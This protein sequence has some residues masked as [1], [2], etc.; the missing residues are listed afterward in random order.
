MYHTKNYAFDVLCKY[1]KPTGLEKREKQQNQQSRGSRSRHDKNV[2]VTDA[3]ASTS[4][5]DSV[6][7]RS[8][9]HSNAVKALEIIIELIADFFAKAL[10]ISIVP[11]V[12]PSRFDV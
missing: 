11:I 2:T 3:N 6:L 7:G 9:L 5:V 12:G 4:A 10:R 1:E 8:K